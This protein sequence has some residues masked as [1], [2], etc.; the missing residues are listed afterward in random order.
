MFE[1]LDSGVFGGAMPK[2]STEAI[3]I[4]LANVIDLRGFAN[5]IGLDCNRFVDDR[6]E[7]T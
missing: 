7:L 5:S 1:V 4:N 3:E 6:L 2:F